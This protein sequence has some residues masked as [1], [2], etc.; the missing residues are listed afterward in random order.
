MV[1]RYRKSNENN[2]SRFYILL[3]IVFIVVM[4]KWGVPYFVN[5]VA[6][7]G[8]KRVQTQASDIIPPQAPILSALPEATNGA[9][10]TVEGYTEASASIDLLVNDVIAMSSKAGDDGGFSIVGEISQG[11]NRIQVRAADQAGNQSVSPVKLVSFDNKPVELTVSTPKDGAEYFG[12]ASQIIDING[13]VDKKDV[14]ITINNSFV[15]INDKGEFSHR[16]QLSS[17]ENQIKVIAT[18]VAGNTNEKTLKVVYT[19]Q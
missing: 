19:A 6:G 9:K 4:F 12:K 3:S 13:T 17:G 11:S 5:V 14:Q 10:L 2:R 16:Y 15:S 1:G 8:A 18:D 7:S